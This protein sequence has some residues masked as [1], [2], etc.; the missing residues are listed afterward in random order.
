MNE[1][2]Q[3]ATASRHIAL[4]TETFFPEINGVA[5]TLTHLRQGLMQRGHRVSLVRPRQSRDMGSLVRGA[6]KDLFSDEH[7]VASLPLPGYPGLQ[8]GLSRTATLTG[9]WRRNRPDSV[10][11]ATQGPLGLAAVSAAR[12]LHIPVC[13][14][15]HT[16]FHAYSRYYGAGFL[17]AILCRY[18]RWFHNRTDLTLVPARR[19]QQL[20]RAMG[21]GPTAVL[22]RGVDCQKFSPCKRNSSLRETWGLGANDRAI[23]HVGRLAPE[24]NLQ[25]VVACFER[26]R[27]LHPRARLILVGDG[28]L[29]NRLAARHPDYIFCGIQQGEA[30]ARHYASSDVFLFPSKTDTYGNVVLEAMASGLGVVA[31]NDAAASEH[32]RHEENGMAPELGEDEGFIQS[33]LKLLEQPTLLSRIRA[34]ARLDALDLQWSHIIDQFAELTFNAQMRVSRNDNRQG[35][36]VF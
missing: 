19:T 6:D 25:M 16:N 36:Q 21:I 4:V 12:R 11:V 10:Y 23:L 28:P 5:N 22:N 30:L 31:F 34:G 32:L 2:R 1:P 26:I 35:I 9:L 29:R 8:L 17:E 13:S 14:G 33:A 7:L 18:G 27:A 15:F 3:P 24:K 20:L